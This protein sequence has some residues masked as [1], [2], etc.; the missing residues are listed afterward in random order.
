MSASA[1]FINVIYASLTIRLI[2]KY[3]HFFTFFLFC[4]AILYLL[5]FNLIL[6][7][8]EAIVTIK[9]HNLL[10]IIYGGALFGLVF[11]PKGMTVD[12]ST[13]WRPVWSLPFFIYAIIIESCLIIPTLYYSLQVYK[14]IE[15]K[16]LK[17]RFLFYIIATLGYFAILYLSSISNYLNDPSFRLLT[18]ITGLSLFVTAFLLYYGV[19][20]QIK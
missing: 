5:I 4:F 12:A 10:A 8:S 17:K 11:I 7:K 16:L 1:T 13:D 18:S 2:V 6:L 15:D 9:K 20:R 14:N 19:A 3:L